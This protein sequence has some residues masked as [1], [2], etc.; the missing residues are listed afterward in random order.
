MVRGIKTARDPLGPVVL[1]PHDPV[2]VNRPSVADAE[3]LR[4]PNQRSTRIS[5]LTDS[6]TALDKPCS[7]ARRGS[8][9]G[10][11]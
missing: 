5:V 9:H 11:W 1:P 10:R 3:L 7:S 4:H 6:I 2:G 8:C